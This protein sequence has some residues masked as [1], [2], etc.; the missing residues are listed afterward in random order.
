MPGEYYQP[1]YLTVVTILTFIQFSRYQKGSIK[2]NNNELF[3]LIFSVAT[4]LFIGFRPDWY[5]FTDSR[6][7][8]RSIESLAGYDFS[9]TLDTDNILFDNLL[10]W[11]GCNS[12][13]WALFFLIIA[14]IY[15]VGMWVACKKMFPQ[16][17][18]AAYLVCLAA[19]STFSYATNGIKAGAAASLFLIAIAYQDKKVISIIFLLLSLGFHHSMV[20]PI[21]AYIL[22][23][24]HRNPKT[25]FFM[26][27]ACVFIA[28]LHIT[29]FQSLFAGMT[30]EQGAGY[31]MS[32]G[33]NWGGREGFR[34]DFVLYSSM[35]V[36]VGWK[37][38]FKRN[39]RSS[40]YNFLLSLYLITNS[41]WML[42]MYANFTNRIAY[43]SWSMYPVVLIYPFLNENFGNNRYRTFSYVMLL[44]LLFTL[45]MVIV[46]Y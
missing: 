25:Y 44:H 24:I 43:L 9:F 39:I 5:G 30:D 10:V 29:F 31:L 14:F 20:M 18:L 12:L 42:C 22:A 45:F 46:Y 21:A 1:L 37:A 2:R 17:T 33:T 38:I 41:I 40:R 23:I 26:W 27:I 3:S 8:I 35:P 11:I 32:S 16:D 4:S 13:G 15:F 6:N 28:L 36:I 34:A 19:F 7:F